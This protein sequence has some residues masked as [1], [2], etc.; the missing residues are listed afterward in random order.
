MQPAKKIYENLLANNPNATSL[1]HIQVNKVSS[2]D[3]I[4]FFTLNILH[5]GYF[6]G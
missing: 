5:S 3:K 1:A 2:V 4:N 6:I